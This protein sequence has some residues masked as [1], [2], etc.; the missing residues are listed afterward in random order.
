MRRGVLLLQMIE[1]DPASG[2]IYLYEKDT[3]AF[4]MISG[5]GNG[6]LTV[7][8]FDILVEVYGLRDVAASPERITARIQVTGQA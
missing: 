8:D 3:G 7:T 1:G 6:H 4:F 2:H 5:R